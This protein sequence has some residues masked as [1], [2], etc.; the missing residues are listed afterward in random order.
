MSQSSI[1]GTTLTYYRGTTPEKCQADC[2]ANPQCKAFTLIK[3]GAYNPGAPPMCYLISAITVSGPSSCCI[4]AVKSIGG[5]DKP[6]TEVDLS[7]AWVGNFTESSGCSTRS[8]LVLKRSGTSEWQ[9]T[10]VI[11]QLNCAVTEGGKKVSNPAAVKVV[12]LG[13]GK[14]Q[15]SYVGSVYTYDATYTANQIVWNTITYTRK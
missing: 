6:T 15:A 12:A 2:G 4:S 10:I 5:G 13:G 9:G 3:A 1:Q 11:T 8:D 7:G 14:A